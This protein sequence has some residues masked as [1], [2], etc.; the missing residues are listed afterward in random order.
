MVVVKDKQ[1]LFLLRNTDVQLEVKCQ[2]VKGLIMWS[3][4]RNFSLDE[5]SV[6]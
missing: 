3:Q 1:L 5:L 2:S 6:K 4:R